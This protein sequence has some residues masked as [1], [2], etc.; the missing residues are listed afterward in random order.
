MSRTRIS[1]NILCVTEKPP[2]EAE[3]VYKLSI[4]VRALAQRQVRM[5]VL[6][7]NL[8]T[9]FEPEN[10]DLKLLSNSVDRYINN[11]QIVD[12]LS[13][14]GSL[15]IHL[16]KVS[17]KEPDIISFRLNQKF[18]I[19]LLQ[20]STVTVYQYYD[21]DKRCS[22]FY[23]PP[24]DKEQLGQICKDN[25]CRCTQGDCCVL[26]T[27]T[28]TGSVRKK[29]ACSGIHHAFKV[30]VLSISTSQYDRYQMEILQVIK[31]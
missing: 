12:N 11:F 29:A 19:G 25:I 31:E 5:T 20:P 1:L 28:Y 24:E 18:K 26:K 3:K 27:S 9:G 15:I 6:D 21:T 2:A 4:S 10:S 14:R 16:F 7:I 22:R 23:T 17:N 30:R 8:P 13:D